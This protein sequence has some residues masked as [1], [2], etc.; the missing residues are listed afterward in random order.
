M[1]S[2]PIAPE[3]RSAED[4]DRLY[5]QRMHR[6]VTAMRNAKADRVPIRPFL[7][8]FCGKLTG[9]DVMQVTHD[10]E[11]AFAAV[12]K[13]ARLLDVD[14]LVGNMVY[15]WTGLVQALGLKYYGI[16][17]INSRPDCGFQ[18]LE[19]PED[20][21]WMR[22]EEYDHLIDDPTGYLYEVWLPRIS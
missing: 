12:R 8:E 1:S 14:A 7:A 4:L 9:H 3:S 6:F 13:T 20:K 11:Q 5:R 15:V 10:F 16:P 18:Y 22:P 21:A 17:G 2:S 19:P